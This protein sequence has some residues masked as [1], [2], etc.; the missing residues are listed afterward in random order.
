MKQR[1][2][3]GLIGGIIILLILF[4]SNITVI[5][6]LVTLI[7]LFALY[8]FYNV[9]EVNKNITLKITG[10]VTALLF[11]ILGTLNVN[12]LI[13]MLCITVF[14]YG[15]IMIITKGN[16]TFT[17]LSK[18]LLGLVYIVIPMMHVTFTK[19]LEFGKYNLFLIVVGACTTDIFAYFTGIFLGK[20][21]LCPAISPKK[22]VEGAIGGLLGA[23]ISLLLT[24][25][26]IFKVSLDV[27]S[28]NYLLLLI[29][30]VLCAVF[31]QF[32]DLTASIIK[33][34][35]QT[36]DYGNVLPGHGGFMDRIDSIIFVAPVVYY[37]IVFFP[38][39]G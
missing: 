19:Q 12:Y 5:N 8:E 39:F 38:I 36:K 17:E 16:I 10:I 29:L 33:R 22:T 28:V 26:I 25:F 14:S 24:G 2:T 21:K 27:S 4:I 3:T 15:A 20:H 37:F 18:A 34:Q 13:P 32:G 7:S 9:V 23:V 11:I 31:A 6:V 30:G 35:Y 1:I